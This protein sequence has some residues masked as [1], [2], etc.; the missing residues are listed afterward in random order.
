MNEKPR[1][2][3][4]RLRT[5]ALAIAGR[6]RAAGY[7][8]FFVGGC[9][10]D[11]LLGT[12][13]EDIDIV[14]S[15][16]PEDVQALFARTV[17]LGARFGVVMVVEEGL[18]FEVA[19]YRV[20][21]GYVDGR[22]PSR[23][24]YSDAR[25]DVLRRDFTVNGLL[26]EPE[27]GRI[28]DH[29]GGIADLHNRVIRTIGEPA[30]RFAEDHLR[31]LRAVRFAA[32]LDFSIDPTTFDAIRRGADAIHRISG[33]RVRE[34][35]TKMLVS[36]GARR[37]MELLADS[38]LLAR[39]LPDVGA[40]AEVSQPPRFHPEGDVWTHVLKMLELLPVAENGRVDARLAWAV[41]LHDIGKA[42]T[43][44]EDERG[45]HFYGHVREG[46]RLAEGILR[47]LRFSNQDTDAVL[48]LIRY[49]MHFMSVGDMRPGTLKRFLRLP[50][51]PLHLE[52]H[53]LDC[54]GSHGMLDS[55]EFC[56]EKMAELTREDLHPARLI[57][58]EDL[59]RFGFAPG[60][61]FREILTAV[62]D[63]QLGGE[64]EGVDQARQFVLERFGDRLTDRSE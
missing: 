61:L 26:M 9:V 37:G 49:H 25:E 43:R 10:R 34:E 13:P 54:L 33:E 7:E 6:L 21:G 3:E 45:V 22:R 48:D 56:R 46:M 19:T 57:D 32:V 4:N 15:A 31:M 16:T 11:L 55:Y 63:A 24:S 52:L 41:V 50:D 47:R 51:F 64:I 17:P 2:E 38:G 42:V 53:R 27:T 35:L 28:T 59:I 30:A 23:V 5:V 58:G 36:R 39:L 20:E 40:L 18:P 62:E 1:E 29:V 8:V 14:T 60:P 12:D 44:T